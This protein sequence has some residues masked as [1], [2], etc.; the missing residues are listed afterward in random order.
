MKIKIGILPLLAAAAIVIGFMLFGGTVAFADTDA[1]TGLAYTVTGSRA[2]ITGFDAPAGF[3]GNLVIPTTFGSISVTSIGDNAFTYG[4]SLA[5]V[6]LPDGLSSIGDSA[7]AYCIS[8]TSITLPDSLLSIGDNAFT[9]CPDLSN[10]ILP[11]N[12]SS[13]GNSAFSYCSA[14]ASITL[15]DSLTNISNN[16]FFSCIRLSSITFPNNITSIGN[17]AFAY[18]SDM[19]NIILPDSVANIGDGAFSNCQGLLSVTIP[20]NVTSISDNTFSYCRNLKSVT[21]PDSLIS[22]GKQAFYLCSVLTSII[23]PDSVKSIGDGAFGY[24]SAMTN[25]TFPNSL[26]SIG[27]EAFLYC[28]SFTDIAIPDTV[29]SIGDG[30][31][32][33][34]SNLTNVAISNETGDLISIGDNAFYNCYKLASITL[35]EST[36]SIGKRAFYY[37]YSLTEI[38]IPNS[39]SYIGSFA[40]YCCSRL[41]NITLP[42]SITSIE[43]NSFD[44]CDN[45]KSILIPIGVTIIGDG[46][47]NYCRNLKS[48]TLPDG[49]TIIGD[50]AFSQCSNLKDITLP[51]SIENIGDGAFYECDSLSNITIPSRIKKISDN[52]FAN[53]TGL[54]N[55]T[56]PNG[57]TNI[58]KYAFSLC[59]NLTSITIPDS[60]TSIGAEAFYCSGIK[61]ITIPDGVTSIDY[62]TFEQCSN[63]ES[64]VLPDSVIYINDGAFSA[65]IRLKIINLPDSL[66]SIGSGAFDSCG[67]L[68]S[69]TI[70]DS[71]TSINSYTFFNCSKLTNIIIPDNV[72]NIGLEAFS[73]CTN[74]VSITI[75]NAVTDIGND[76]FLNCSPNLT[77]YSYPSSYAQTYAGNNG[78]VFFGLATI[79]PTA[80]TFDKN[81]TNRVDVSTIITWNDASSVTDVKKEGVSIGADAYSVTGSALAFNTT[82]SA[83]TIK[84][85]YLAT[86]ST[87]TLVLTVEFDRG[88][89][90]TLTIN[91]SNTT[92]SN[93]PSGGGGSGGDG[94]T[95]PIIPPIINPIVPGFDKNIAAR[96]DVSTTI[97]WNDASSVV[98]IKKDGTSIGANS[99][100]ING[101]TLTTKKEYLATQPIGSLVLTV[102]FDR[103][104]PVT[105]TIEISDTTPAPINSASINPASASFDKNTANRADVSTAITWNDA[106]AVTDVK[107]AGVSIGSNAYGISGSTLTI[108]KD[109]LATQAT[110][111][112]ALTVEFDRGTPAT[113]TISISDT[114]QEPSG[115]PTGDGGGGGGGLPPA[116]P[117]AVN[118]APA[119][120]DKLSPTVSV[121]RASGT[122]AAS[123][124]GDELN[125]A[126]D[127]AKAGSD[128]VKTIKIEI[129]ETA[130]V[131]SYVLQLPSSVLSSMGTDRQIEL[132][133]AAVGIKLPG[134]MLQGTGFA[135]SGNVGI[136]IGKADVSKLPQEVQDDIGSRPVVELKLTQGNK[137]VEWNNPDAPVTVSVPYV[138]TAEELNN[139]EHIVIWYIDGAGNAVS[140]PSGRYDAAAGAVV[141]TTTHFSRYA[142]AY[143]TTTFDDLGSAAWA[144]NQIEMLASKGIMIGASEKEFTPQAKITRSDFMYSLIRA[145]GADAEVEMNFDDI[146]KDA[147]YYKEIGI[148]KKLSI[149]SG[150]GNNGFSPDSAITRQ[151]MMVLTDKAL[152]LVKKL[153]LQGP[154]SELEKFTDRSLIA[155]YAADSIASIVKEG[156]IV[157]S[158]GGINPLGSTTR[159]EA[160]V[161]LYKIYNKY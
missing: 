151:D 70:P 158:D 67:N 48:I 86:Q 138:P 75:P 121:D 42:D 115:P 150:T 157:G 94:D 137:T 124:S 2:T 99:Y 3:D 31:F 19:T 39:V 122:A 125:K 12:L 58:G 56:I 53:C 5:S 71:V 97:T 160:A 127:A 20:Y 27:N 100:S 143:V 123:V 149:T 101:N 61:S 4:L 41:S 96:V 29:T 45:L 54:T 146:D 25:I 7:F 85:E 16:A 30:A 148:A 110:G 14:I 145:L 114:T 69:I 1:A 113:L 128:G 22:I 129:P 55:I 63:L 116:A 88:M 11:D 130:G 52:A 32:S 106:S 35:P 91:I 156:L 74:L 76:A 105:L 87:G 147:Y 21:M 112:L 59:I 9:F 133:S 34:C 134:N 126:F 50:F 84:K 102:E 89:P 15:P 24:C 152:K 109:F 47:F 77:I 44:S 144:K 136:S 117:P 81:P 119:A 155:S 131:N 95:P 49:V 135:S 98:D 73:F 72:T 82:A 154:A 107:K 83:L 6:T 120:A 64:I 79:N 93:P 118:P 13:I 108:R 60:V 68:S 161:F 26:V 51:D 62:Y 80:A 141:F 57:V 65:C 23:I 66:I 132:K 46:A 18:C 17:Y 103:G 90:A 40:F 33:L 8:L 153:K 10:I 78:I 43:A 111:S 159:A 104:T 37:C 142:V 139:P 38:A 92:P 36:K 28:S 140:I